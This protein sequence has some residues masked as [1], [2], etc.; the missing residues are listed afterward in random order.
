ML[1][2]QANTHTTNTSQLKYF[3]S[4]ILSKDEQGSDTKDTFYHN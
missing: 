3:F 4:I 2:G 1:G